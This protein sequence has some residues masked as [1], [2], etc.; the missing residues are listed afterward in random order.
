MKEIS[1]GR[2]TKTV[3]PTALEADL[4]TT[5]RGLIPSYQVRSY[6]QVYRLADMQ[7]NFA[8]PETQAPL[9]HVY[10]VPNTGAWK[11][12][13]PF[14]PASSEEILLVV[15][16]SEMD[17]VNV[18][19]AKGVWCEL[20]LSTTNHDEV[21]D[22]HETA[23]DIMHKISMAEISDLQRFYARHIELLSKNPFMESGQPYFNDVDF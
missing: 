1:K 2:T 4:I 23:F 13:C 16:T 7:V 10:V 14:M 11:R 15:V 6:E 9:S 22:L 12:L 20:L 18:Y 5:I 8:D 3:I 19:E 17:L 21:R